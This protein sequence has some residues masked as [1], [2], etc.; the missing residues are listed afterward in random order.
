MDLHV[1]FG[2]E[3][4][5]GKSSSS[6]C[7]FEVNTPANLS[8]ND[9]RSKAARLAAELGG[10]LPATERAT[11]ALALEEVVTLRRWGTG[12]SPSVFRGNLAR[13]LLDEWAVGAMVPQD[14]DFQGVCQEV[15]D[16]L[17]Q[18]RR[19]PW[20]S[21]KATMQASLRAVQQRIQLETAFV[22]AVERCCS[23]GILKPPRRVASSP[24]E[25]SASLPA[26]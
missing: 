8:F 5:K 3:V 22:E 10:E 7:T 23:A 24:S 18:S 4:V 6:S 14:A 20:L 15:M 11:I 12:L 1:T 13:F 2:P 26:A 19:G 16:G 21:G 9:C 17:A 25:R